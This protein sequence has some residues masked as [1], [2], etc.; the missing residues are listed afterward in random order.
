[1]NMIIRLKTALKNSSYYCF[2]SFFLL[3]LIGCNIDTK[4][5]NQSKAYLNAQ[6]EIV[7]DGYKY[8][9]KLAENKGLL[10][11]EIVRKGTTFVDAA[12]YEDVYA[13]SL[14]FLLPD[15]IENGSYKLNDSEII[16]SHYTWTCW[17]KKILSESGEVKD[18]NIEINIEDSL[19]NFKGHVN[20]EF[21]FGSYLK[22]KG[23]NEIDI[24]EDII[25]TDFTDK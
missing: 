8:Y 5:D 12:N 22:K 21:N 20:T 2:A 11:I 17:S 25:I 6:Y 7:N 1:M 3:Y 16:S 24:D 13:L 18:G 9:A 23:S 4:D 10:T 14:Y 15:S 19:L